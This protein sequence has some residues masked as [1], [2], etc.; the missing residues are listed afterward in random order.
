MASSKFND[1]DMDN[2]SKGIEE[3]TMREEPEAG[4]DGGPDGITEK[5]EG[6]GQPEAGP[7]GGSNVEEVS[8]FYFCWETFWKV[9]FV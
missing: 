7:D 3:I 1:S 6:A 5:P 2:L 9:Y 4:P 8:Y